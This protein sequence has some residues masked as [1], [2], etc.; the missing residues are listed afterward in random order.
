MAKRV[1]VLEDDDDLRE[2][3]ADLLGLTLDAECVT[4]K[5]LDELRARGREALETEVALLDVNLGP[6]QPSG[7]D[8][9]TWLRQN[10]YPGRV[11]F[12]TG[13]GGGHPLVSEAR[14][15][16]DALLL[17][18]PVSHEQLA[19]LIGGTTA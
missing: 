10:G 14:R 7:V 11:V 18:K 8:A 13:H 6:A 2:T 9:Y 15:V 5:S 19:C 3:L 16:G 4:A 12:L 1:V 17:T